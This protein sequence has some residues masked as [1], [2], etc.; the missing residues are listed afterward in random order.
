MPGEREGGGEG[1]GV[2][3]WEEERERLWKWEWKWEGER[4]KG[5]GGEEQGEGSRN[6]PADTVTQ[7]L[8]DLHQE[9]GAPCAV[10]AQ[11]YLI[12]KMGRLLATYSLCL[13]QKLSANGSAVYDSYPHM[14]HYEMDNGMGVC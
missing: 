5:R 12:G 7:P 14:H 8:W 1:A 2:G 3:E 10:L 4:G 6:G 11:L 9:F 13:C